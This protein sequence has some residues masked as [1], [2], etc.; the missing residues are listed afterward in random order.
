MPAKSK[1]QQRIMALALSYKRGKLP[2]SK[3]SATIRKIAKTMSTKE[4]EKFAST[5]TKNL[6]THTNETK[7]IRGGSMKINEFRKLVSE[8]VHKVLAEGVND[9]SNDEASVTYSPEQKQQ[10]IESI[11]RFNEYGNS[12]YRKSDISDS[13]KAINSIVEFACQNLVE[14]SGEWF[15][16]VTTGRHAKRLKESMKVFEKTANE[17]MKLQQRLESAYEDIGETLGKYYKITDNSP[18]KQLTGQ[19]KVNE[20]KS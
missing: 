10:Y 16:N 4:L 19:K 6:H 18:S 11:A 9:H 7:I 5:S 20:V 17:V 12:I 14:E 13:Y 15:D 8:A 2:A 3:V 1:S